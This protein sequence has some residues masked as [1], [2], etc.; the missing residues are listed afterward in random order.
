MTTYR[1]T[2]DL[3]LFFR[4]PNTTSEFFRYAMVEYNRSRISQKLRPQAWMELTLKER[5][6]VLRRSAELERAAKVL[7]ITHKKVS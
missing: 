3:G 6:D 4:E 1:E 2:R 5:H 7:S